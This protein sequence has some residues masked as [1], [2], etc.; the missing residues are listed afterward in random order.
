MDPVHTEE[1]PPAKRRGSR[2]FLVLEILTVVGAAALY[3]GVLRPREKRDAAAQIAA[4]HRSSNP[5]VGEQP[6][7]GSISGNTYTNRFFQFSLRF[8]QEWKVFFHDL[9]RGASAGGDAILLSAG[10]VD[11]KTHS[12][13]GIGIVAGKIPPEKAG[14]TAE[15]YL[16]FVASASTRGPVTNE[17]K[18][19]SPTGDPR[20]ISLGGTRMTRLDMTGKMNKIPTR[21]SLIVTIERGYALLFTCSDPIGGASGM[22]AS[23]AI[24]SLRFSGKTN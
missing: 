12:Q 17:G 8:P 18:F 23:E 24:N 16:R 2:F 19:W 3:V 4:R 6:T 10:T 7:D 11:T 22:E 20:E 5:S 14:I 13:W 21:W 9:H 1:H 15:D